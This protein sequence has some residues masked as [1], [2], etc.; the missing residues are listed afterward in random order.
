MTV[1]IDCILIAA[2]LLIMFKILNKLPEF[3]SAL[4]KFTLALEKEII[5]DMVIL[6]GGDQNLIELKL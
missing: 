6:C 1:Y 4:L 5:R 2:I 3:K